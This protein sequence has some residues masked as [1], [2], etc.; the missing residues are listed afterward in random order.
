M[1]K[2]IS[3]KQEFASFVTFKTKEEARRFKVDIPDKT[4]LIVFFGK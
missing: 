1:L 3:N 2:I 4:V